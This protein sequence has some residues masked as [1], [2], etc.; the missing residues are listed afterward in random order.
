MKKTTQKK[1]LIL[2]GTSGIILALASPA[3]AQLLRSDLYTYQITPTLT[4]T[5]G[6]YAL[7]SL[8]G[9]SS[10]TQ[11]Y[12]GVATVDST[13]S[14]TRTFTLTLQAN[15]TLFSKMDISYIYGTS[16]MCDL[17]LNA[18]TCTFNLALTANTPASFNSVV[19]WTSADGYSA[20]GQVSVSVGV[21]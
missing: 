6:A 1:I 21:Q 14:G 19:S 2:A 20:S 17:A 13:T 11:T 5:T 15:S 8:Q 9:G 10:G 16:D 18:P 3:L 4:L 7:G 12:T